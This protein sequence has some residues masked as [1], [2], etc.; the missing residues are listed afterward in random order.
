[1]TKTNQK[2][3][4]RTGA[5][6]VLAAWGCTAGCTDH[7]NDPPQPPIV[8]VC[9]AADAGN[10]LQTQWVMT[11]PTTLQV[12]IGY[13]EQRAEFDATVDN[14]NG[15]T[16][17]WSSGGS[18]FHFELQNPVPTT[19]SF[20]VH[21]HVRTTPNDCYFTQDVVITLTPDDLPSGLR[22]GGVDELPVPVEDGGDAA[23][24]P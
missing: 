19:V 20:T 11:G 13:I 17:A 21:G 16:L 4:L 1:V 9:R 14:L 10:L 18:E 15:L 22:D 5:T 8:I 6:V 2:K 23:G 7:V 12:L 3:L 24:L